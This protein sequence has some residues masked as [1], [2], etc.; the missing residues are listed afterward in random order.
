MNKKN[1]LDDEFQA[2]IG[3]GMDMTIPS[4]ANGKVIMNG[5]ANNMSNGGIVNHAY[6]TYLDTN[7]HH[8]EDGQQQY[9]EDDIAEYDN[10]DAIEKSVYFTPQPEDVFV[11][12]CCPDVIYRLIPWC[13]GD[14]HSPFW[15][16]WDEHRILGSRYVLLFEVVSF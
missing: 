6:D 9:I 16:V 13:D 15:I 5:N 10:Y 8:F 2:K 1:K 3:H 7:F 14:K 11:A 4:T 12:D